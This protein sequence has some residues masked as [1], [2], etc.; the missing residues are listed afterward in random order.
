MPRADLCARACA[1]V[2]VRVR[3]CPARCAAP[4][5][6]LIW[7]LA[8]QVVPKTCENFRALCTGE[9]GKAKTKGACEGRGGWGACKEGAI[10]PYRACWIDA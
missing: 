6:A 9:K 2:R 5:P 10:C 3:V 1:R 7:R 4:L 8:R